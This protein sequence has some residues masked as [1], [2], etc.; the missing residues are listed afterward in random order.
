MKIV[1]CETA[2]VYPVGYV[3]GY[4]IAERLL[5]GVRFEITIHEDDGVICAGVH[6]DD[7][8]YCS[9]FSHSQMNGWCAEAIEHAE[10]SLTSFD[11]KRDLEIIE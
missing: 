8:T 10:D 6:A 4:L 2:E 7:A 9:K 11:G 5:E 3:D 1:D